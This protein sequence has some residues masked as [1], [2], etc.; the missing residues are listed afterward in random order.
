[1][2]KIDIIAEGLERDFFV[3]KSPRSHLVCLSCNDSHL[4]GNVCLSRNDSY[5]T[6]DIVWNAIPL[7]G[8]VLV[9]I[10]SI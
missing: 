4:T 6:R 3:G 8:R 9:H 7:L 2:V 10:L 1:M 5:L